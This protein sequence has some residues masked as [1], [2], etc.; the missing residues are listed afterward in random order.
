MT[1]H[2]VPS[3]AARLTARTLTAALVLAGYLGTIPAANWLVQHYPA[4]PV[5][6]GL[7]APAG[8]YMVGLAL[9]LRD[10]ARELAGREAVLL[11]MVAGVGVSYW[12]ASPVVATASAAAFLVSETL[13]FAVYEQLRARGRTGALAASNAVGLVADSLLFLWIAFHSLHYL[14]GQLAGKAWMTAAAVVV[15]AGWQRV[16][17]PGV[18]RP[19]GTCTCRR[20]ARSWC[21]HCAHDRCEDCGACSGPGCTHTCPALAVTA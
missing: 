1:D 15:L 14:G 20:G 11:A 6:L 4:A 17:R 13:D 7:H 19:D 9:V 21:G 10:W 12:L 8:V 3:P 18:L 16:R 5:P 2:P